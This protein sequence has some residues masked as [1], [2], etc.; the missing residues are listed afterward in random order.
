MQVS[1]LA[2]GNDKRRS[3]GAIGFRYGDSC[4]PPYFWGVC[5][6]LCPITTIQDICQDLSNYFY[7]LHCFRFGPC[8]E[9]PVSNSNSQSFDALIQLRRTKFWRALSAN[10]VTRIRALQDIIQQRH[11][12]DRSPKRSHT[13]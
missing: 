7:S 8:G 1:P 2:S 6:F 4:K 10:W 11:I 12:S 5:C 13:I 3:P 9:I